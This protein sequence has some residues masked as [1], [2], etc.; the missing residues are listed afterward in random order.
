MK[1]RIIEQLGQGI[2][3]DQEALAMRE[4]IKEYIKCMVRFYV[5]E[6]KRYIV[7]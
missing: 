7:G 6:A 2:I 1:I 4:R 5:E 3:S